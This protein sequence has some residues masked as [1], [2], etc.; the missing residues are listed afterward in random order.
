MNSKMRIKALVDVRSDPFGTDCLGCLGLNKLPWSLHCRIV[1][2][3]AL[4]AY[5]LDGDGV[6]ILAT[7][8]LDQLVQV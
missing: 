5:P 7:S 8:V 2:H 3:V 1:Q 6:A 4:T